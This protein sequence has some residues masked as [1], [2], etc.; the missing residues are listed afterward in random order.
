MGG[1]YMLDN[2]FRFAVS[3]VIVLFLL[4]L[5]LACVPRSEEDKIRMVSRSIAPEGH[6][7]QT[8]LYVHWP[9][10]YTTAGRNYRGGKEIVKALTLKIPIEYLG[11]SLIS[12]DNAFKIHFPALAGKDDGT[13]DYAS[14]VDKALHMYNYR[15][16]SIYLR[17][18]PGAKPDIPMLPYESDPPD[19]ARLKWEHFHNSYAVIIERDSYY[20]PPMPIFSDWQPDINYVRKPDLDGLERYVRRV[21]YDMEELRNRPSERDKQPYYGLLAAKAA[22][23]PSPANCYE[24]RVDQKFA[25]SEATTSLDE[26]IS[27]DCVSTSCDARFGLKGRAV[28]VM[29]AKENTV[30]QYQSKIA[31]ARAAK[32]P[33]EP[34]T[35]FPQPLLDQVFTDLPKWREKIAPTQDLLDSFVVPEDSPEIQGMF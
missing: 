35:A 13:I 1:V 28:K 14:R 17:F 26:Q 22:D 16:T 19:V 23:D 32:T 7:T 5:W 20:K 29:I 12:F 15:I 31:K 30:Y 4:C 27:I 18:Q 3:G 11:Q 10:V 25:S 33:E 21:C 2:M 8:H 6:L 34:F 9:A 24:D